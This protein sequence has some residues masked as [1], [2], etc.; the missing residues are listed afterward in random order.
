MGEYCYFVLCGELSKTCG[1]CGQRLFI[2]Y[3]LLIIIVFTLSTWLSTW[4]S[5][6]P[7]MWTLFIWFLN[8]FVHL[9]TLLF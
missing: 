4:V 7:T 8:T 1:Q 9:S 5:T 3:I 6:S 2:I